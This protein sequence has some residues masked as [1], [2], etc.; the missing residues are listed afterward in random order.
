VRPPEFAIDGEGVAD[1]ERCRVAAQPDDGLGDLLGAA[2]SSERDGPRHHPLDLRVAAHEPFQHR[3]PGAAGADRVHPDALPGVLER[4]RPG[5]PHHPVLARDV[6]GEASEAD[7]PGAGGHVLQAQ[8]HAGEVQRDGP[9]PVV[10]R[11]IGGRRARTGRARVVE[12][13]V[14]VPPTGNRLVDHRLDLVGPGDVG[15][16]EVGVPA[17]F[18]EHEGRGL[19]AAPLVH[20]GDGDGRAGAGERDG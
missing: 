18:L 7:E 16:D 11:V 1:D 19:L 8:E 6:R 10:E 17:G 9:V 12:R 14:E 4:G 5:Q 2:Q 15:M 3:R 13:A 20:V